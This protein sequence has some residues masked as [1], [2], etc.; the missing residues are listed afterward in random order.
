M[1]GILINAWLSQ[2]EKSELLIQSSV[3]LDLGS[4]NSS[5]IDSSL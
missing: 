4:R 5:F 3:Q 1:Y 2:N